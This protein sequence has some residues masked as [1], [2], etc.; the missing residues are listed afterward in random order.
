MTLG[1]RR[2]GST[3]RRTMSIAV[4]FERSDLYRLIWAEPA[5]HIAKKSR[6]I[7]SSALPRMRSA[8]GAAPDER[9]LGASH[10]RCGAREAFAASGRGRRTDDVQG[11][12]ADDETPS[13]T[14]LVASAVASVSGAE[15]VVASSGVDA[16]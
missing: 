13:R 1:S 8:E 2:G 7:A 16:A 11:G 9:L 4:L 10:A 3:D 12:E 15:S 6:H 14:S 5:T